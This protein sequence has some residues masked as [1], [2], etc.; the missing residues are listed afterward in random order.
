MI[1]SGLITRQDLEDCLRM[2]GD[3]GLPVGRILLITGKTTEAVL[4]AAVQAQSLLKDGL[5]DLKTSYEAL[6]K[7]S[8]EAISFREA[9]QAMNVLV[10]EVEV[11][12]LGD[13]LVAAQ[14]V[15]REQLEKA[16]TDSTS[17]G[18]PFGRMLVI[19]GV[20]NE[21]QLAAT[22]NAQILIRDKKVTKEQAI[23]GLK[24]ARRR[25]IAVEVPLMEKGFYKVQTR[26]SIRLGE[27]LSLAGLITDA[28][29]LNAVE[30]GL[31]TQKAV[32]QVLV[33]LQLITIET[34]RLA[35]QIQELVTKGSLRPLN[36]SQ[37][38][39]QVLDGGVSVAEAVTMV[40]KDSNI[41]FNQVSLKDFL[42]T[43]NTVTSDDI[44]SAFELSINNSQI[45]GRMLLLAGVI[46]EPTLQAALRLVFLVRGNLLDME[47]AQTAFNASQRNRTNI[48]D[49]LRELNFQPS[50]NPDSVSE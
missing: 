46:D 27:L 35:L 41:G 24:Q 32:G 38:L 21:S 23:E 48:D 40:E 45:L 30:I 4:Q 49:V 17:S 10:A 36:A 29:L 14:F 1:D 44:Q 7:V 16:L 28:Q 6:R 19:N 33:D 25:Q 42:M 2:A 47:Q 12:K 34:L 11:N 22:L 3:T 8:V 20:I 43:A 26:D 31:V 9:L 5:I 39:L 50:P 15:S 37:V 18:L 13:L